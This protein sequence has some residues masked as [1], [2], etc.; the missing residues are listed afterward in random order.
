MPEDAAGQ[1]KPV[2]VF[3]TIATMMEVL[4]ALAWQKMG[5]QP[6]VATGQIAPDMKHA[7]AAIDATAALAAIVEPEL[8]DPT[9]KRSVQNL[10]RDLRI[11]FVEKSGAQS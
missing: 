3:E 9:E 2:D 8:D 11:N 4:S 10:V 1:A 5:L 6:D 7:K